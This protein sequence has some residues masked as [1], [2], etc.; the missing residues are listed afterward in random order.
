MTVTIDIGRLRQVAT[1]SGP[2]GNPVPDGDGDYTQASAAL[3]PVTWRCA[4]EAASVSSAERHFAATVIAQASHV[5]TG[6]FHEGINTATSVAWTDRA[7][8]SHV[9]NVL[10]VVDVEGAGV[11]TIV[12]VSEV[13]T[14]GDPPTDTSWVQGGWV[15]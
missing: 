3:D 12:L 6:R 9:A 10:D 7:G 1:L 13:I 11:K 14:P 2:S 4:I 5:L 15:Q 8:T